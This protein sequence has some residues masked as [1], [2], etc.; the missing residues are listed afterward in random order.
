M[1]V[2]PSSS[3]TSPLVLVC[4][5]VAFNPAREKHILV[6]SRQSNLRLSVTEETFPWTLRCLL[7]GKLSDIEDRHGKD[8]RY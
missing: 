8:L 5:K 1:G 6:Q 2:V 3:L 4:S 7:T